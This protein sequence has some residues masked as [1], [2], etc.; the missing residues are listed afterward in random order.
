MTNQPAQNSPFA[1]ATGPGP[2]SSI[3][4]AGE[5]ID[6]VRRAES[7]TSSVI[8]YA[9]P[10]TDVVKLV[11]FG[12]LEAKHLAY[13]LLS[14]Q[15]SSVLLPPYFGLSGNGD[16]R[17]AD[18]IRDRPEY[19]CV[20]LVTSRDKRVAATYAKFVEAFSVKFADDNKIRIAN[21]ARPK[22]P[23]LSEL[24]RID[25]EQLFWQGQRG[26]YDLNSFVL[27]PSPP[28]TDRP[29]TV[30][31]IDAGAGNGGLHIPDDAEAFELNIN[32]VVARAIRVDEQHFYVLPGSEYRLRANKS[33]HRQI[34]ARRRKI[35]NDGIL[36]TIPG[37]DSR[38][39]LLS[40]V[41][42]G[43]PAKAAKVLTG[44]HLLSDKWKPVPSCPFLYDAH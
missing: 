21:G 27:Y 15:P 18:Q 34:V 38:M 19:D 17:L 30:A 5:R 2:H 11:E 35:E 8:A 42:L 29:G 9:A 28:A 41:N 10:T 24:E 25:Y 6:G 1:T 44:S 39:R 32:G 20:A 36:A 14:S 16:R 13:T 37:D 40:L 26:L 31:P 7:L 33:L 22:L 12:G 3:Y 43:A 23:S 4:R